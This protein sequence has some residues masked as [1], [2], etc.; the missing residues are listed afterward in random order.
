MLDGKSRS[1]LK[2]ILVYVVLIPFVAL[3]LEVFLFNFRYWES[4]TFTPIHCDDVIYGGLEH[5]DGNN[6]AITNPNEVYLEVLNIN[7]K[8]K[9]VYL[10]LMSDD[11]YVWGWGMKVCVWETDEAN[12]MY[13]PLPE[14]EIINGIKETHYIRL[15]L[16]GNTE[17][18]RVNISNIPYDHIKINGFGLNQVRPFLFVWWRLIILWI[19]ITLLFMFRPGSLLYTIKVDLNNTHQFVLTAVIVLLIMGFMAEVGSVFLEDNWE[20]TNWL[21]SLQYNYMAESILHGKTYLEIEPPAILQELENPYDVTVRNQALADAGEM[22]V[23]D[24]AY[25]NGKYYCYYGIIPVFLFYIPYLVL[26]GKQL[27]SGILAIVFTCV[28]VAAAFWFIYTLV[29]RY[30]KNVSLGLYL[31]MSTVFI[32]MCEV[33][34]CVQVPTIYVIPFI[35]GLT[36]DVIGITCWM[37]AYRAEGKLLKRWLILGSI[38]IAMVMGCRPQLTIVVLFAFPIFWEQIREGLFFTIK[39]LV[40]TLCVI[41][42]FLVI[43]I[44]VLYFNAAR[45]SGPLDFGAT[46]NL[47]GFDMT[48]RGIIA[49]RLIIGLYELLF[50]PLIIKTKFPYFYAAE[51]FLGLASD[52]QGQIINEQLVAGFFG[53]NQIGLFVFLI[54]KCRKELKEKRLWVFS[55]MSICFGLIIAVLDIQMVGMT[56]RYLMDFSIFLAIVVVII[57]FTILDNEEM[58]GG[59]FLCI[60]IFLGMLCLALNVCSLIGSGRL[61]ELSIMDPNLYNVIKYKIC[62][63]LSIR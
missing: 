11:E 26:T 32:A 41:V 48:H 24:Y 61:W 7:Q 13:V 14:T 2:I 31:L 39:G 4:K 22:A 28:F 16:V 21:A 46:Y 9:N 38:I 40:N 36:F 51:P 10:N 27:N 8:V 45:F 6:Y 30:F 5:I 59:V 54:G 19:V 23:T 34:Y 20:D 58:T 62:G 47:T 1:K 12:S 35:L 37:K 53:F 43:G 60:T 44:F 57:V 3:L 33:V 49:E 50:Q 42:P 52:Y 18:I 17:K 63:I 56:L 15:H 29:R 25:Y 55:I